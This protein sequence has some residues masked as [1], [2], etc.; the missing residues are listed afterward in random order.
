MLDEVDKLGRDFRGDPEAVRGEVAD[1]L[2]AQQRLVRGHRRVAEQR[3]DGDE[4]QVA[5]VVEHSLEQRG[6]RDVRDGAALVDVCVHVPGHRAAE[7]GRAARLE[8]RPQ[9][10]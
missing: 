9:R 6:K 3:Q 8:E 5:R 4:G 2:D 1:G 10:R 7:R